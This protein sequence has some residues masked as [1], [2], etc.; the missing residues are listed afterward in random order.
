[1]ADGVESTPEGPEAGRIRDTEGEHL[2]ILVE[3]NIEPGIPAPM[4]SATGAGRSSGLKPRLYG[5]LRAKQGATD[6]A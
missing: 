3:G 4:R 6:L 2:H 1:M 5:D